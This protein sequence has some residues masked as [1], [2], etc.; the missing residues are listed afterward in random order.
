M[1]FF[2]INFIIPPLPLLLPSPSSRVRNPRWRRGRPK[3][4]ASAPDGP[5]RGGPRRRRPPRADPTPPTS[6]ATPG[7]SPRCRPAARGEGR[8]RRGLHLPQHV[9]PRPPLH[10]RVPRERQVA[11]VLRQRR[12]GAPAG[13]WRAGPAREP[14]GEGVRAQGLRGAAPPDAGAQ[15]AR[16]LHCPAQAVRVLHTGRGRRAQVPHQANNL[17]FLH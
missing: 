7:T 1:K 17:P 8:R 4:A 16:A 12:G 15:G 6:P 10:R 2:H 11:Q 3:P 5:R 13:G 14:A 9:Q